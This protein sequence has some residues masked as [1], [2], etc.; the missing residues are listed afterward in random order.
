MCSSTTAH[1]NTALPG[2]PAAVTNWWAAMKRSAEDGHPTGLDRFFPLVHE[3]ITS[4]PALV[5]STVAVYC[6][7]LD[8][9][10]RY[11]QQIG[12]RDIDDLD[13][14]AVA[15]FIHAPVSTGP[16]SRPPRPSTIR[17][18]RSG[19]RALIRTAR[20]LGYDLTDPTTGLWAKTDHEYQVPVCVDDH[21]N[22]LRHAAPFGLFPSILPTVLALA[23]AGGSNDEIRRL[24]G[25]QIKTDRVHLP[26]GHRINERT[27]LLTGW[28]TEALASHLARLTDPDDL[29]IG[30]CSPG[31]AAVSVSSAF[32]AIRFHAGL[33]QYGYRI[34]SVRAWRARTIHE[35]S[36]SI[37]D[38]ARFLGC[39]S[40]DSAA[41]L[42]GY[43]WQNRS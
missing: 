32:I 2:F 29:L 26:G 8:R 33:A 36:G 13:E 1:E 11:C 3:A 9:L 31:S 40:L 41:R 28:G 35:A 39:T 37:E 38:A 20:R 34:N 24:R 19:V 27:N 21:I 5:A 10:A 22:R 18:R 4:D 25:T 23:E 43:R 6:Q 42:V 12:I 17:N 15:T 30:S 16:R 14:D 7:V